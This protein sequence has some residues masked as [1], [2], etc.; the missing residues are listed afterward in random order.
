[1]SLLAIEQ[2]VYKD[3]NNS[4][5]NT[6]S[7]RGLHSLQYILFYFRMKNEMIGS[8]AVLLCLVYATLIIVSYPPIQTKS[9]NALLNLLNIRL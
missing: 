8:A 6:P 4:T 7:I 9:H 3:S 2:C 1:M 5:I